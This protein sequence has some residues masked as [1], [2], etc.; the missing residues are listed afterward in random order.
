MK[1]SLKLSIDWFQMWLGSGHRR[2]IT[3]EHTPPDTPQYNGVAERALG[4]LRE[5]AVALMEELDEAINVPREKM[6][7]K[8]IHTH[9]NT[10]SDCKIRPSVAWH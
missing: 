3:H 7:A 2:S 5:K 4:L 9:Y 6:W 1:W 10:E 8:A